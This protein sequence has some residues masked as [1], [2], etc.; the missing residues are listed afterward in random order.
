MRGEKQ[1]PGIQKGGC[2]GPVRHETA[3]GMAIEFEEDGMNIQVTEPG[4]E[5]ECCEMTM[6]ASGFDS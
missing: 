1:N 3:C 2:G 4:I 6:T 5:D